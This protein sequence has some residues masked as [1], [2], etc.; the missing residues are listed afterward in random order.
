MFSFENNIS[1]CVF[2]KYLLTAY[3]VLGPRL[4]PEDRFSP[5]RT[6]DQGE[7]AFS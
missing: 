3:C 4:G 1:I 6:A 7:R 5:S 2:S